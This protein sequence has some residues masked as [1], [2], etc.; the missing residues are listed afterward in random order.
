M[1][2]TKESKE[3]ALLSYNEQIAFERSVLDSPPRRQI[4]YQK[5]PFVCRL[6]SCMQAYDADLWKKIDYTVLDKN[7]FHY[8][9]DEDCNCHYY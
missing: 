6:S 9:K 5:P 2:S 7:R 3:T 8:M 4:Y 1:T